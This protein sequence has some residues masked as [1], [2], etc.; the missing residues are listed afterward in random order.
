MKPSGAEVTS[1]PFLTSYSFKRQSSLH[2]AESP[3]LALAGRRETPTVH[4]N[5]LNRI[6]INSAD[7]DAKRKK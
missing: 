1:V 6:K 7:T 4:K 5:D 3:S 2:L